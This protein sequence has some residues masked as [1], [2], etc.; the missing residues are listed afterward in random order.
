LGAILFS[1]EVMETNQTKPM[2]LPPTWEV[3]MTHA[4]SM[5][6]SDSHPKSCKFHS[7][8]TQSLGQKF[9]NFDSNCKYYKIVFDQHKT[10]D[11]INSNSE[12][13]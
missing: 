11:G 8:P 6:E 4:K 2:T 5:S 10:Y 12:M 13:L 7:W 9:S 1:K 3:V